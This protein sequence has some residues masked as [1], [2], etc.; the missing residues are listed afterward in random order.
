M[1][2]MLEIHQVLAKLA[3]QVQH[4]LVQLSRWMEKVQASDA[5]NLHHGSKSGGKRHHRPPTRLLK[6][7]V[8]SDVQDELDTCF[9]R[10]KGDHFGTV[11]LT[12]YLEVLHSHKLVT[13]MEE[14]KKNVLSKEDLRKTASG[15]E[16]EASEA[17][18]ILS[19]SLSMMARR[20]GT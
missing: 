11:G 1:L 3:R 15:K 7:E 9:F 12:E 16:L 17:C 4:D 2:A 5:Y 13:S 20:A 18:L 14:L 6:T 10:C 8:P 19:D